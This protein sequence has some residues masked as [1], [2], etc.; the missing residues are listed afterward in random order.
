[1]SIIFADLDMAC[2]PFL[3]VDFGGMEGFFKTFYLLVF[4]FFVW[5]SNIFLKSMNNLN[6]KCTALKGVVCFIIL[7]YY[8]MS[9]IK[10]VFKWQ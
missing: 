4:F 8:Q 1:M 7:L 3:K 10:G 9:G 6:L 2:F 5:Y